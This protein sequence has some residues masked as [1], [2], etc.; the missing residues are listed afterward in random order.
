M[1]WNMTLMNKQ[2]HT[3]LMM[4]V[5]SIKTIA[6]AYSRN[7]CSRTKALKIILLSENCSKVTSATV[8]HL[9]KRFPAAET[10]DKFEHWRRK[11]W[12]MFWLQPQ[13]SRQFVEIQIPWDFAR[14]GIKL[15][16]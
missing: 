15:V 5:I 6:V 13:K 10:K 16:I 1:K 12:I 4:C 2:K 9:A 3:F 8:L 11:S 7:L 14:T